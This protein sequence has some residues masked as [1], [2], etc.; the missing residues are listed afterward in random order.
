MKLK[1]IVKAVTEKLPTEPVESAK[2]V[3][4]RY[5]TD[6]M[7]GF[8]RQKMDPGFRPNQHSCPFVAK[9]Y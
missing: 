9:L 1:E 6:E 4:L 2:A 5:V 7:P 3:G 8:R